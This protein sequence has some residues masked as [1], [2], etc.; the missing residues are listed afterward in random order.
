MSPP[1]Q[2]NWIRTLTSTG[3]L[4]QDGRC[5]RPAGSGGPKSTTTEGSQKPQKDRAGNDPVPSRLCPAWRGLG[6]RHV[7]RR[8]DRKPRCVTCCSVGAG[9]QRPETRR[10]SSERFRDSLLGSHRSPAQT[11]G[12]LCLSAEIGSRSWSSSLSLRFFSQ[13]FSIRCGHFTV[14]SL[15]IYNFCFSW[16]R[17]GRPEPRRRRPS[18]GPGRCRVGNSMHYVGQLARRI[19]RQRREHHSAQWQVVDAWRHPNADALRVGGQ[20]TLPA[21]TAIGRRSHRPRA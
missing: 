7:W 9:G 6:W 12:A 19:G 13:P 21:M 1:Q 8:L 17:H 5:A 14:R 2:F 10:P 18:P 20:G 3:P 15:R 16:P 4:G 11:A